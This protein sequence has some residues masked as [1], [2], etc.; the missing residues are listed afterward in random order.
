MMHL[1]GVLFLDFG[2]L[3]L[4]TDPGGFI[5]IYGMLIDDRRHNVMKNKGLM[6]AYTTVSY[7]S[8]IDS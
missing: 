5:G 3:V 2:H 6:I 4:C 8:V 7:Q 1:R